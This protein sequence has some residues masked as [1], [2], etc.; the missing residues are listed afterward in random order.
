MLRETARAREGIDMSRR[1]FGV[2]GVLV[3]MVF[4]F[5]LAVT[6]LAA[7]EGDG[8]SFGDR[9]ASVVG[10]ASKDSDWVDEDVMLEEMEGVREDEMVEFLASVIEDGE[11]SDE[12]L[13]EL[14]E[15]LE[16]GSEVFSFRDFDEMEERF[17][18][19]RIYPFEDDDLKGSERG[20]W[21]G[22]APR[23]EGWEGD[24]DFE[25]W[26]EEMEDSWGEGG[27]RFWFERWAGR[28]EWPG[29]DAGK[30][31]F[32]AFPYEGGDGDVPEWLD[33]FLDEGLIE[34]GEFTDWLEEMME[35]L[36]MEFDGE[37]GGIPGER[38]FE[39]DSDDG[40]FRFRG[41]WRYGDGGGDSLD[42]DKDKDERRYRLVP[43][44]GISF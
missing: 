42:D 16:D 35:D 28:D 9:V 26:L 10:L 38:Q 12:E 5:G 11:V 22:Y 32:R 41:E 4:V 23:D 17:G 1:L 6:V 3:V 25:E 43:K 37:W 24:D 40:R 14:S 18:T 19:L 34:D 2:V 30:G 36:E 39:F 15:W 33:E 44:R 31:R 21:F 8:D 27:P 13:E 29:F 20:G 7:V